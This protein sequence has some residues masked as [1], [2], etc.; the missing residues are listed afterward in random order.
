MK[1]IERWIR[2]GV[3]AAASAVLAARIPDGL[4][5]GLG[6]TLVILPLAIFLFW[7]LCQTIRRGGGRAMPAFRAGV[8]LAIAGALALLCVLEAP[9][10]LPLGEE[11]LYGGFLLLLA[12]IVGDLLLASRPLLGNRLNPRPSLFFFFFPLV[13]YLALLP[14]SMDRHPPDGDEPFYLLITHSLAY[15]FDADLTNNYEAKDWLSFMDRPIEPQAGDPR[16]PDGKIYSR[17]NEL[18]PLALAL[19]YR[20]AGKAGALAMMAAMTALLAWFVLRLAARYRPESPGAAL[21][22]YGLLAFTPP[23]LLFSTQ[24]WAEVPA[25]LLAMMGLDRILALGARLR[26]APTRPPAWDVRS[27][28]GIG[29]PLIL[30]PLLKIRFM[31]LAAPLLLLAWCYARRPWRPLVVL[32]ASLGAVGAG[33]LAYNSIL[34]GNPLKIHS[35]EEL[36]LHERSVESYLEGGVGLFFDS[37]FGLFASAPLWFLALPALLWLLRQR[38]TTLRDLAIFALPYL[39]VV[40]PR[41]EWYGG[42]S[43]PFRYGLFILP[44][45]SLGVGEFLQTRRRWGARALIAGLGFATLALTL[46]WLVVPGWTYNFAD[47]RTYLLDHLSRFVA[48]DIA[49][50]FPSTIRP[51]LATWLWPPIALLATWALWWWPGRRQSRRSLEGPRQAAALALLLFLAFLPLAARHLP[52]RVAEIEDPWISKDRGH[53]YPGRWVIERTRYRGGWML[54]PGESATLPLVSKGRRLSLTLASQ[55]VRNSDWPI[56]LRIKS[57]DRIVGRW[58]PEGPKAWKEIELGPF[59]WD[60]GEALVLEV[61]AEEPR[62]ERR[63]N[64]LVIDRVDLRWLP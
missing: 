49:R 6:Q 2:G 5:L 61:A 45:L 26:S 3:A 10:Q 31:L 23:L 48:A 60:E 64:G 21:L 8:Y 43:P 33:I 20:L 22:A 30:L 11:I 17:H 41:G 38:S 28:L 14:W 9:L 54:R 19:P 40:A 24:V 27:W 25:A 32:C 7:E 55:F 29:L 46:L 52:T 13:V 51:R 12:R 34:Y 1:S 39:L 42:W 35:M 57:G 16:G 59:L 44:L 53:I 18:L 56:L 37:A 15:D 47:G 50:F 58:R 62:G 63:L 4:S 36:A